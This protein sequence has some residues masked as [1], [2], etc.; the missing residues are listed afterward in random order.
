[1]LTRRHAV[2]LIGGLF[3]IGIGAGWNVAVAAST[4]PLPRMPL[5]E[6]AQST[7]LVAALRKG[8]ASMKARK[9]SDPL[10]WFYQAAIHGVTDEKIQEATK[11]DPQ[12]A[13]VDQKKY[14]NQCPHFGQN[15]ANFLPWH[16][17]Y[18]YYFER[19]LR[20]HTGRDDFSLPY[21][22]YTDPKSDRKFPAIY[23]I[24]YLDGNLDN[25]DPNNIN[26]LYDEQRDF[27]FTSYQHPLTKN[28]PLLSL[29]DEAV[30]ISLP[31]KSPVFFG[32]TER[33]GLGGGIADSDPSTRGL[34]ESYP[35]DQIHRATG[36]IIGSIAGDMAVP[37][38]AG[39]D[40]IFSVHHT[41][42]DWL[43]VRWA[44]MPAKTWGQLPPLSWFEEKPWYFFDETGAEMNEPRRK[45]FNHRA[46]GIRFK[47]EDPNCTPLELPMVIAA[48][49]NSVVRTARAETK[50]AAV[51]TS[52]TVSPLRPTAIRPVAASLES[53][54]RN[55]PPVSGAGA[56]QTARITLRVADIEAD[57][58]PSVGFDVH[59]TLGASNGLS[60]NDSTFVGSVNLFNHQ[61]H[62][63]PISQDF[64]ATTALAGIPPDKAQDLTIVFV[65]YPLLKEVETGRPSI[66]SQSLTL[67]G[68]EFIETK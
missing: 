55:L 10:S 15:S 38:T 24:Q 22:N 63:M 29:T 20:L 11:S 7:D 37:P 57:T 8:V 62:G 68:L 43:W 42:I 3:P 48:A 2:G 54:G 65:P 33:E 49:E 32:L 35:H 61:H 53:I 51:E 41:N 30:D 21:W 52:L 64:D 67:R 1:M 27:Y 28:L 12:V 39:F 13:N 16:R 44:C 59:V 17:G 34:L 66:R 19:I 14:W 18:T 40:P 58:R 36:G 9:P 50:I 46:L 60:R 25:D 5:E 6:F 31:M 26:P 47:N 45:Y 56:P 4:P 23:G